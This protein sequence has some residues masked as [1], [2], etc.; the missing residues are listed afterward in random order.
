MVSEE[1]LEH[2]SRTLGEIREQGFLPYWQAQFRP[3]LHAA[4]AQFSRQRRS[5]TERLLDRRRK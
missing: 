2:Y 5:L 4:A 1:L 3:Y